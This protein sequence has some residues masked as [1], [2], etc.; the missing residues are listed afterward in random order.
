M[1]I[2]VVDFHILKITAFPF[3]FS[4][5]SRFFSAVGVKARNLRKGFFSLKL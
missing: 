2:W 4:E 1:G 5:D 3:S